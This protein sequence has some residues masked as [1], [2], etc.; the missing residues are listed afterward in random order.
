MMEKA[1]AA[2][3]IFA[4][5]AALCLI[6]LLI[7]YVLQI[8]DR[9]D[10]QKSEIQQMK[11]A[12]ITIDTNGKQVLTE[13]RGLAKLIQQPSVYHQY[14]SQTVEGAA[15]YTEREKDPATGKPTG[16]QIKGSMTMGSLDFEW[17]GKRYAIPSAVVESGWLENGQFRFNINAKNEVKVKESKVPS[18]DFVARIGYGSNS[19]H[20]KMRPYASIELEHRMHLLK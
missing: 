6:G 11:T 7:W 8:A 4:Q 14:Y 10:G 1:K 5:A 2:W 19:V 16:P 13:A 3:S 15:G 18:L 12:M 20:D 17:N 9:I